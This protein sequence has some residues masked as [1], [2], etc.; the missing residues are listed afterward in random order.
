MRMRRLEAGSATSEPDI[1]NRM[2]W[3]R[4]GG[5]PSQSKTAQ[6]QHDSSRTGFRIPPGQSFHRCDYEPVCTHAAKAMKATH[7]PGTR[8][9]E[10]VAVSCI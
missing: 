10:N 6:A 4:V 7:I 3:T 9:S 2:R 8:C 1:A 5:L